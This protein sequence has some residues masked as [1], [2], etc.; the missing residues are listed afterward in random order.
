MK[1]SNKNINKE[2]NNIKENFENSEDKN[3]KNKKKYK[4][5]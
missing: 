2:E 5:K 1:Y 4:K 3:Y